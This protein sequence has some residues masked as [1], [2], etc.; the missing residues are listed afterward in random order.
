MKGIDSFRSVNFNDMCIHLE[1]KFSVKFNALTLR[2]MMRRVVYMHI[3]RYM[4]VTMTQY[5]DNDKLP[6]QNLPEELDGSCSNLIT[7]LEILRIKKWI[8]LAHLFIEQYK[9]NSEIASDIEQLQLMSKK[10]SE[11]FRQYAQRWCHTPHKL[12]QL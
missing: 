1:L 12:S 11:C 7:T 3:S 2:Y 9:F 5:Y 6:V 8:D 10:P 4:G